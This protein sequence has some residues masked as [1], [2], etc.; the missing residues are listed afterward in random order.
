MTN[1]LFDFLRM[2]GT[3]NTPPVRHRMRSV[4]LVLGLVLGSV[5]V[6]GGT[7]S[8]IFDFEA[9]GAHRSSG[10]NSYAEGPQEY[11][12]NEIAISCTYMDV[13]TTG[14]PLNGNANALGRVAKNKTNS[15]VLLIGPIDMTDKTITEILY[16]TMGVA[17]M[18]QICE[19]STNGTS[20]NTAVSLTTMPTSATEETSETISVTGTSTF[21]VR[22]TT[23]V[24]S[25]T[26]S[27]RDLQ[28]DDVTISYSYEDGGTPT[29][30]TPTFSP[31]AGAVVSGTTVELSTTTE[32]A[33]IHYTTNGVD[34]TTSDATYSTPIE[35]TSA[36]T[37]KAMAV[38]SGLDNSSVATAAYTIVTPLTT[39][40]EIF[41]RATEVGGTATEVA[42][43]FDNWV[44]S[45]IYTNNK[46]VFVTDGTKGFVIFDG[47]ASMGFNVGDV[48]SGTVACKVQLYKGAA[49]ITNL[50]SSTDGLTVTSGGSAALNTKTIDQ[51]SAVNTG[52]LVTIEN[53]SY[54]GSVFSDGVNEIAPYNGLFAYTLVS[55]NNY[56]ITG[57]VGYYNTLQIMPRSAADIDEI[58]AVG[59]PEAPVFSP[60]AG[61][62]TEVQNV[63]LSCATDG[64]TIYYTT[65][66]DTPDDGSTE[67]TG[68]IS[69][70]EDM[71][72]KAVAYKAGVASSIASAAYVINLPLTT[73]DAI[74]TKATAVGGTATSV[75]VVFDNW[76]VSG[77]STN[78]KNVYLTDGTKGLIIYDN[79][80]SMGFNV[81]DVLSGTVA[82]KVQLFNGASELTTLN[83]SSTGLTINTG[84]VITPIAKTIDAL[85]GVNT[86]APIIVNNVQYN[87]TTLSDGVNTIK[88]Y[89]TL[90]AYGSAFETDKYYNVTGIYVQYNTTK[91]IAPRSVADIEEVTLDD[92]ELSYTPA[93]VTLTVGDALSAPTF[94]NPHS[95]TVTFSG[96]NDAVAT[97]DPS[98]GEITLVGGTGTAVITA[99]TDGNATY[100]AGNATFTIT[101]NAY[102][103]RKKAT[104]TSFAI[105]GVFDVADM[106]YAAY[107]GDAANAVYFSATGDEMRLYKP[108]TGK[109]TGGYIVINAKKGCTIDEVIVYNGSSKA[110]TIGCSTTSTLATSG[111]T[112]AKSASV[113]FTSL[114]ATV[115]YIDN[116]GSDRM[117][118][119]KIEVFYTG[120][121]AAVDHYE[122]GGTYQ[123][124]FEVGDAF[125]HD[126]LEVYM[127]FDAGGTEKIDLTTG[128]TFSE[129]DMTVAGTPTVEISFAG[130]VIT[131]YDITVAASA[132]LDPELSYDPTSV[133]LTQGDALS[134]PTLNNPH[135]LDLTFSSNKPAVATVDPSTGEITLVGG[136]GTA[137]IT[138]SFAGDATYQAG[139]ATFTITVNEPV[140]DLTGT[141][142]L[143]TSVAAG[144]RIIIASIADAGAVT[145]MG[146]QNG[147]NRSGVASTVAGT[148]L[149]PA[150]GSKSVT[151]VDAGDGKFALQLNN[152]SYLYAASNTNN[153]LKETA[154]Y[155]ENNNA[156]WTI[157]IDGEGVATITAQG[158]NS[159]NLMRYNPNSGSPLFNCYTSSSTTGTLVTIYKKATPAKD[160]IRGDLSAGKW[161]TICPKQTVEN[162]EGASFY[163][164][165]YLEEQNNLPYNVVFDQI[166][167]TT[168]TAGQPYFFIAEGEEIKG[169]KTGAELDAAD[170]AGVNGFYGYIGT[171]SLALTNIH[172]EYTPG[173]DNTFVIYNNSVFRINSA[174]NLKSERCYININATEPTRTPS[175]ASPVRRRIVMGVQNTNA[176]TGM[177]ELNASE[178]P[179]KM[180]IDGKMYILRGEKMYNAN[181]QLVK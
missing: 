97:V 88:P 75:T 39:M 143:A 103:P 25:S 72:I 57:V 165:T 173:E 151:L 87:G 132:L 67:Y 124:D 180:I 154:A 122:L 64:A 139:N 172:T 65:N 80:G 108:A 18:S 174:T 33:T 181:G 130:G 119:K 60:V 177:D 129:P 131:S 73:M 134:A 38:K 85:S 141:W 27:N 113:S 95:L 126:G 8:I 62:Y 175:S 91:E 51:L 41:A 111:E 128:C 74:F 109:E 159:H 3:T 104:L 142:E 125:N 31:V 112:Y 90:F 99:H 144:D 48:L 136:T 102:D 4:L 11:V 178:A 117:D 101:V 22:I 15:P 127:A 7:G 150:A 82:C 45:G 16:K 100:S 105:G 55:G 23:S 19:Y 135:T 58:V 56:N 121:A 164:I 10:N 96:N 78:G 137:V 83:S 13:V 20:W 30:A 133:T 167:G 59:A 98:T 2:G 146:A 147:N 120:D 46:N 14:S 158:T 115:V 114:D 9:D 157:S 54:D 12:Q 71:T 84:G 50:N 160:V 28:I 42:V 163:Q 5:S 155:A 118:I 81:G 152:G 1:N 179:R 171:S 37:I 92:P 70:N 77:V 34:P 153:Y 138:A 116:I 110:T 26:S 6:W 149:T 47:G 145:T 76:V 176:A 40:D 24:T 166:E 68:A 148:E 44:V 79:G 32:G 123:T 66:G 52:A 35:I 169:I 17:A 86:G 61:T 49:E 93:S 69:V 29:C 156:K 106:I 36:T 63:T 107:K 94:A 140:E 170:P 21:Y 162:V 53:L 43:T 168:L 89:N 161:G